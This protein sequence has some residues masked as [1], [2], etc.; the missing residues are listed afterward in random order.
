MGA[1]TKIGLLKIPPLSFV[2]LRFLLASIILIPPLVSRKESL[3]N[4]IGLALLSLLATANITFFV[5]GVKATTATIGGILYGG[6]PLLTGLMAHF[7]GTERLTVRKTLGVVIGFIGVGIL[8][9]LPVL[10]QGKEFSGDFKGNILIGMGV[11]CWSFY[12]VFSKKAQRKHSPFVLT[13]FSILITTMVLLP[14]FLLETKTHYA[15]WNDVTLAG[16]T[17]VI[18]VALFGT[19]ASYLLFQYAIKHGGSVFASMTFYLMPIF[20]FLTAFFLLGERL[21]S[22]LVFGGALSLLGIFLTTRK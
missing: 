20:A 13:S 22:R 16:L 3:K 17:S 9:F 7:L 12:M 18:Y 6:V 21:T 14:F 10:E 4:L 11:I 8:V 19:I 15:W 1:V 5:L 2:F